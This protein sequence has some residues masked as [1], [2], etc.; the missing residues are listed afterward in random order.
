MNAELFKLQCT[1]LGET[2]ALESDSP[3]EARTI[4]ALIQDLAL[5]TKKRFPQINNSHIFFLI[6]LQ[7]AEALH[8]SQKS[9]LESQEAIRTLNN[10]EKCLEAMLLMME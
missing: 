1:I 9:C 10:I 5:S 2:F 7:L 3:D 6:S 4:I 8:N